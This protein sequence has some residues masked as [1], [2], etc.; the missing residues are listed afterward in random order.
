MDEKVTWSLAC[1]EVDSVWWS[2]MYCNKTT[3][4]AC[5]NRIQKVIMS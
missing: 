4:M 3:S 2:P 1:P 5:L